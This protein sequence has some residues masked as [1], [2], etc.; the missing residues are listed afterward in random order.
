MYTITLTKEQFEQLQS[1]KTLTIN[2]N[3]PKQENGL[4]LAEDG[5]FH[6]QV[7]YLNLTHIQQQVKNAQKLK[8]NTNQKKK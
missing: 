1:N 5:I 6:Q 7:K 8:W 4:H 2:L 3:K